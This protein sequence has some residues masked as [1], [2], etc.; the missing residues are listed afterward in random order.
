MFPDSFEAIESQARRPR[1]GYPLAISLA[2]HLLVLAV[3]L[4]PLRAGLAGGTAGN[5][6]PVDAVFYRAAD[7]RA[8]AAL[9]PAAKELLTHP[10]VDSA[11]AS[12]EAGAEGEGGG[13]G[14]T[15]RPQLIESTRVEPQFSEAALREKI[16]GGIVIL[17]SR[18]DERGNVRDVRVVRGV[19]AAI[20]RAIVDAVSC[21]KF[22]PATRRGRPVAVRYVLTVNVEPQMPSP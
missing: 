15:T 1:P 7:L 14:D 4:D 22:H 17:E 10:Y 20:D 18:I 8:A 16:Q 6:D 3:V 9:R 5:G 12:G 21:W 11:G 13:G 2:L 19:S